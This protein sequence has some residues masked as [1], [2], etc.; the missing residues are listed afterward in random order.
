MRTFEEAY[1]RTTAQGWLTKSE[2]RL[3][4]RV[5]GSTSGDILEVGCYYGRSAILLAALE[6]PV[7]CVDPF[8]NFDPDDDPSGDSAHMGFLRNL[9]ERGITNVTLS[10][11]RIENW[12]CKPMGFVYL[13][14]DHTYQGTIDQIKVALRCKPQAICIHDYSPRSGG[15]RLVAK[16]VGDCALDLVHVVGVLAYVVP[17][18]LPAPIAALKPPLAS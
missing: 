1:N 16:A 4:W 3:L 10:R 13:D 6:R 9:C 14:G 7:Y 15:G 11:K 12:G 5:A 8:S 2:A 17:R 18:G